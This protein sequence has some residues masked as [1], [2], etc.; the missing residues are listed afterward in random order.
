MYGGD[1][2]LE[3]TEESLTLTKPGKPPIVVDVFIGECQSSSTYRNFTKLYRKF[4]LKNGSGEREFNFKDSSYLQ[5]APRHKLTVALS[6]L[7]NRS[8]QKKI[9]FINN[10]DTYEQFVVDVGEITSLAE[11]RAWTLGVLAYGC[12]LFAVL[13]MSIK[14]LLTGNFELVQVVYPIMLAF[15]FIPI[16][17]GYKMW[18]RNKAMLGRIQRGIRDI[19][20]KASR[21][22]VAS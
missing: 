5:I 9:I 22:S 13:F 17:Y 4:S 21:S 7:N 14:S 2:T 8:G 3:P 6:N 19:E 20:L 10:H 12:L 18:K 16:F 11:K 1:M 15:Y